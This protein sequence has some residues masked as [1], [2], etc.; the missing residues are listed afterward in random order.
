MT[1]DQGSVESRYN[2]FNNCKNFVLIFMELICEFFAWNFCTKKYFNFFLANGVIGLNEGL[3]PN[4]SGSKA[5][6]A[7]FNS[8]ILHH[9]YLQK[10]STYD[11]TFPNNEI[12]Q[13]CTVKNPLINNGLLIF[14]STNSFS[15]TYSESFKNRL[16]INRFFTFLT[17]IWT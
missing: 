10:A 2:A 13:E 8:L 7:P 4:F 17:D 1:N 3:C 16:F 11:P 14:A 15:A 12:E 5:R 9:R 6:L